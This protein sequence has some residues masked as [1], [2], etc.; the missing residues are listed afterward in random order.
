MSTS[1]LLG[2]TTIGHNLNVLGIT[3]VGNL[4]TVGYTTT[5]NLD[6][7]GFA[8]VF[9]KFEATSGSFNLH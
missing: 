6:V 7:T 5:K 4:N 1:L 2:F 3:S 9:N 8:T